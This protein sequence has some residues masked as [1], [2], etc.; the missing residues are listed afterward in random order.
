M[1]TRKYV[2]K[3]QLGFVSNVVLTKNWINRRKFLGQTIGILALGTSAH[4]STTNSRR[5]NIKVQSA[6]AEG[7]HANSYLIIGHDDLT[8]VDAQLNAQEAAK[9]I[10]FIQ[11]FNKPLKN[12]VITHSHPDH[13]LG[14]EFIAP[15]F[16]DAKIIS[17]ARSIKVI[18]RTI[19]FWS[20]FDNEFH[21]L[22]SGQCSFSNLNMECLVMPDAES[23][24]PLV[25]YIPDQKTLIAGD[26]VLD[27]QH[28]WLAEGR[29]EAWLDNLRTLNQKWNIECVLPGHGQIGGAELLTQT[30]SYIEDFLKLMKSC[31]K[32]LTRKQMMELYPNHRFTQA[33]DVS[34]Q[35]YC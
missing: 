1:Q 25:L 21:P 29:A 15:K 12:I 31:N 6:D 35:V 28:L 14:L 16:P 2:L 34:L 26:H 19:K 3:G 33:L 20:N 27:H 8:L 24:A 7:F 32:E 18:K 23:I 30:K 11:A 10:K 13:Y 17:S 4:A 22:T 5:Q 9:L